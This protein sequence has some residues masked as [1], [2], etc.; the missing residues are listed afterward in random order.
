ME[1]AVG[2]AIMYSVCIQQL[3]LQF[4]LN[5][6]QTFKLTLGTESLDRCLQSSLVKKGFSYDQGLE[7]RQVAFITTGEVSV[8]NW[9]KAWQGSSHVCQSQ[10]A[11]KPCF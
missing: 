4:F 11:D 10:Y 6:F 7:W 9:A 1:L 5:V 8:I 3:C 2:Q